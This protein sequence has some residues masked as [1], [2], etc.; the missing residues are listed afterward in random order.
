MLAEIAEQQMFDGMGVEEEWKM[1]ELVGVPQQQNGYDCGV[2]VL[3][4]SKFTA[5]GIWPAELGQQ[6]MPYYR[7]K[8]LFDLLNS[9][10]PQ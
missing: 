10:K 7:R 9:S 5:A 6:H 1:E 8:I 4:F 2:F 3:A